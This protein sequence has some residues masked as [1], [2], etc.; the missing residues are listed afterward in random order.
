M[1]RSQ[2]SVA[3][4]R[5]GFDIPG[6]FCRIAQSRT[7]LGHRL[8]QA[9]VKIH[10]RVRRPK[11]LAQFVSSHNFAGM[12][13]QQA[14]NLEGLLLELDPNAAFAQLSGPFIYF[15]N[16]KPASLCTAVRGLHDTTPPRL[17]KSV[18]RRFRW[19]NS[20]PGRGFV[21]SST[22]ADLRE[23]AAQPCK[24]CCQPNPSGIV[25]ANLCPV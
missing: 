10:K 9:A 24:P 20:R 22:N 8:V 13:Q 19:F 16:A 5:D 2:E 14:Q 15:E 11:P 7:Q 6:I 18:A 3:V 1:H 12:I 4:A 23:N 17:R 21:P 25:S